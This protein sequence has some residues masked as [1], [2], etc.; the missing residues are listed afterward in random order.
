MDF[1]YPTFSYVPQPLQFP[2]QPIFRSIGGHSQEFTP[3]SSLKPLSSLK[4]TD[5]PVPWHSF[6][7]QRGPT[8]KA[9]LD[10][11]IPATAANPSPR[12]LKNVPCHLDKT[13]FRSSLSCNMILSSLSEILTK[14]H[15]DF[16]VQ[17]LKNKIKG[18]CHPE[19]I[20]CSFVVNVFQTTDSSVVVEFQRRS[21]CVVQFSKFY[22][23]VLSAM[24]TDGPSQKNEKPEMHT[25][26]DEGTITNLIRMASSE[27]VDVQREGLRVL[28]NCLSSE[29]NKKRLLSASSSFLSTILSSS[30]EE[31]LRLASVVA[32]S[33][34]SNTSRATIAI[35]ESSFTLLSKNNFSS[36]LGRDTKRHLTQA[37]AA[38]AK[39]HYS[40]FTQH[41]NNPEY[42][43]CLERCSVSAD[44][45]TRVAV[46]T[47]LD[48]LVVY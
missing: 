25:N 21:G 42:V 11:D 33:L 27:L 13:H 35:A 32:A 43:A 18:V 20:P 34:S 12:P 22:A 30:D 8:K 3:I 45:A 39:A 47:A 6:Q 40:Y 23:E 16:E 1:K 48:H 31:V 37:I 4:V 2:D 15:I 38:C 9:G 29:S 19:N 36:L 44:S 41:P 14:L 28:A 17:Y 10:L 5:I 7:S 46:A 24:N 26:L